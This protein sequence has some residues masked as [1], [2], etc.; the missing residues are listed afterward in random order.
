MS[1]DKP[2]PTPP[3]LRRRRREIWVG[4]FVVAGLAG[5]LIVLST[6]TDAALFR[7]RYIVSTIVPDAAGIRKGDPVQMRGVNIGRIL[8]FKISTDEVEV[9]LEIEGEYSVP[10]DSVVE[11]KASGLLGGLVADVIPGSSSETAV[12]GDVLEGRSGVGLFDKMDSL[13]GEAD[14]V[15]ARLKALLSDEMVS[16]LHGTAGEARQLL[17]QLSGTVREQRGELK[18]LTKSLRRSA[19]GLEKV[20]TGPE[21]ENTVKRVEEVASRMDEVLSGLDRSSQSLESI[22]GRVDRGEGTLGK[23]ST[24]EALYDNVSSAA[25]NFDKA[26]VEIRALLEDVRTKPK[27]YIKLSLF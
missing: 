21:I 3:Q 9:R 8:G 6:M 10:R 18:A 13:A 27:K 15:A 11:L 19:E 20:T 12:W 5:V 2:L 17:E 4:L 14:D 22:L 1:T 16:N 7:G 23:L 26:A 24:D 25:A